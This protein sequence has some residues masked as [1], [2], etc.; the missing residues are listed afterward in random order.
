MVDDVVV[1][2]EHAVR[3]PVVAQELPDIL[4]RVQFRTLRRQRHERDVGRHDELVGHVP[5][6]LVDEKERVRAGGHRQPDLCQVP[7]HRVD[8]AMGQHEGRALAELRTDRAED[9][10]RRGVLV[11][12]GRRSG[13]APGPSARDL[14]LLADPGFVGEPNLYA[15]RPD[16]C[17]GKTPVALALGL[18]ACQRGLSVGFVTAAGLVHQLMEARDERRLLKL[19]GQLAALDLLIVDKLGYV[20]LSQIGAELLFEVFSQRHERGATIVTSNLPF[21][22]WTSVFGVERLTG[23]RPNRLTHHVHILKMNGEIYRL[24]QSRA[25][26]RKGG[27]QAGSDPRVVRRLA[28]LTTGDT[29]FMRPRT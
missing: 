21:E 13:A 26:R 24:G 14:V 27:E 28:E 29:G 16:L 20:P 9:V 3:Q 10:G 12:R 4:D 5:T 7:V 23:A 8:V 1:G 2:R 11:V 6:G 17:T 18:A 15:G 22:D 25:R 19:Q